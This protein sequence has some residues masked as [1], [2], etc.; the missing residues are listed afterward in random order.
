[1]GGADLAPNPISRPKLA[2]FWPYWDNQGAVSAANKDWN[3]LIGI[4]AFYKGL[5]LLDPSNI[6]ISNPDNDIPRLDSCP[7]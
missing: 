5:K 2:L 7:S 4:K 1:M 3:S 6:R